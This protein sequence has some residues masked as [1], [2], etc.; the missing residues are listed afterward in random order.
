MERDIANMIFSIFVQSLSGDISLK[1]SHN[2]M[3]EAV[4]DIL[5]ELESQNFSLAIWEDDEK[6]NAEIVFLDDSFQDVY[7]I[8]INRILNKKEEKSDAL[9][10]Q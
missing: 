6:N 5:R 9:L 10:L 3:A 8:N 1:R 2:D 7:H 4:E